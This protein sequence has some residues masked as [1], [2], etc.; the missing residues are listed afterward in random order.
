MKFEEVLPKMRDEGRIGKVEGYF[1]K[2][3][4]DGLVWKKSSEHSSW[5]RYPRM[6]EDFLKS[7]DWSLE[8]MKVKKW[9]WAFG[10]GYSDEPMLSGLLTEEEAEKYMRRH[11]FGW[12]E[13]I[14]KTMVEVEL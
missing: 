4:E 7:D 2:L 12:A 11:G 9:R 6:L 10:F 3:S 13:K 8:P 5:T 1:F 14:S